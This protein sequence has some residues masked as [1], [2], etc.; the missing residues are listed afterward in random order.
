MNWFVRLLIAQ[1]YEAGHTWR[2]DTPCCF[3]MARAKAKAKARGNF[4][5]RLEKCIEG[6]PYYAN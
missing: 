4:I 6:I 1:E 2:Y 5:K 3:A